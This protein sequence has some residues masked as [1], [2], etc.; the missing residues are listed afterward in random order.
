MITSSAQMVAAANKQIETISVEQAKALHG[1]EDV[2]FVDLRDIRELKK[3]GKIPNALHAPR[4]MVEFWVDPAGAY[5]RP[6]FSEKK[7]FVFFCA[8]GWRSALTTK[9]VQDMGLGSVCH[10][11]GGFDAWKKAGGAVLGGDQNKKPDTDPDARPQAAKNSLARLGHPKALAQQVGFILEIDKL[12]QIFRQTPLLDNSR[13]E[14][15]AEHTW[16]LAM[17]ALVFQEYAV[18]HV[19]IHR[20]LKMLLI[21][22]IVEIDAGDSPAFTGIT[23][24]DQFARECIA[25]DRLFNLL[26]RDLATEF[27]QLW[28]EFEDQSSPDALYSRAMDRLQPFLHNYFTAGKMWI[29]HKI[30]VGQ[31]RDRMAIVAQGSPQIHAMISDLTEDAFAKGYLLA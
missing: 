14:N 12:K 9:T 26:P 16:Q 5:H 10:I 18:D 11:K 17:M 24:S 19:D 7:K 21:H 28:D 25:A 27:R 22:D 8:A 1:N 31:V 20:V 4:G 13:K 23:K 3:E 6:E 29:K 15:D 2:L 30:R